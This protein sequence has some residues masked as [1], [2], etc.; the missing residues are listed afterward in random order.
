M[1]FT[2]IISKKQL[3]VASGLIKWSINVFQNAQI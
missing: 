1:S 3:R 2:V